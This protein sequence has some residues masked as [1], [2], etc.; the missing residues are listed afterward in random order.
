MESRLGESGGFWG[1]GTHMSFQGKR[2]ISNVNCISVYD[3]DGFG[4]STNSKSKKEKGQV[5]E[6]IKIKQTKRKE[7]TDSVEMVSLVN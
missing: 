6:R 1:E 7:P 4:V 2:A 3:G 5:R